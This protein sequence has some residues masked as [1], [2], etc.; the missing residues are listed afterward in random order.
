MKKW[1]GLRQPDGIRGEMMG[2][3]R[4]ETP[5]K[6]YIFAWLLVL[7]AIMASAVTVSAQ[8]L[9]EDSAMPGNYSGTWILCK[10]DWLNSTKQI[11]IVWSD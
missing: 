9:R 6:R 1:P 2:R 5:M 11:V 4:K 7:V 3:D 10:V 8:A